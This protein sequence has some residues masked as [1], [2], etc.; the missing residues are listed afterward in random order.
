MRKVALVG[1]LGWQVASWAGAQP[2]P[3]PRGGAGRDSLIGELVA[4][5]PAE[6]RLVVRK[7]DGAEA[8]IAYNEGTAFVRAL[9]G[10][11]TL[12]GATSLAPSELAPGDR[13][14]C[15]GSLAVDGRELSA[16]RVV[17]M[18]RGD[19]EAR[20][21][22]E[23]EDWRWR[24]I[25]GVVSAVDPSRHEI[26]VRAARAGGARS[27]VVDAGGSHVLF[28]RY[29]ADSV[30]FSDAHPGSFADLAAGDQVRVLGNASADGARVAAEQVVSGSFHVVRGVVTG[31]DAQKGT[32]AVRENGRSESLV[33]VSVGSETLLRR[34]PPLM[35][36]RLL[37]SADAGAG[38]S[39]APAAGRLPDPDEALEQLPPA[40]LADV[41][42]GDEVAVLGP[43]PTETG[44]RAIKLA[45]WTSEALPAA[46]GGRGRREGGEGQS[47]AFS[48]L[49]GVG[50]ESSW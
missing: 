27:V 7:D 43:K 19:I 17:V 30:R 32:I 33:P 11:T 39:A 9:P 16:N 26:T 31:I 44:L 48:D 29:A 18:T 40:A 3:A 46:R 50:G 47:D 14:L 5:T 49:L 21:E 28:R 10:A 8:V 38:G 45:V 1:I 37:R 36:S 35:V 23:R 15:R 25:A 12:E 6:R 13:L 34:L 4:A 22:R 42:K 24:G 20:R 41:K 2:S